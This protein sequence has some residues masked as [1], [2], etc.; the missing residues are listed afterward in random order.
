MSNQPLCIGR[1]NA[2]NMYPL[3]HHLAGPA[4]EGLTF[5]DGLPT[6]LNAALLEGRVDI[7]AVSSIAYAR[8]ADRLQ[9]LPDACIAADGAVDSI[10]VF[11]QLPFEQL[12]TV[13][14]TP[15][16]ATSVALL[17]VLVGPT[18]AFCPLVGDPRDAP[19]DGVLLIADE[20]L[21]VLREGAFPV[22]TDLSERWQ[23][24]TGHPMVFAVWAARR[25]VVQRHPEA[26][27]A[28]AELLRSARAEYVREPSSAA[29]AAALRFG[30]PEATVADYFQRLRYRFGA[31]EREG[32]SHFLEL[33]RQA[34]EL[35]RVPME[36][37]A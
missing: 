35:E 7:S 22:H 15:H 37:A 4:G 29:R 13:A 28:F 11:S 24:M 23:A 12:R 5:L 20:A 2:L 16:S 31:A 32:L 27:E 6:A 21:A 18:V 33:A 10:Q 36:I 25:D 17:R 26:V 3:Y 9:I 14:I 8:N 1:I 30:L 34:G 19:E